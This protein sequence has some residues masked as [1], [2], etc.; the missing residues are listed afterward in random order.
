MGLTVAIYAGL[1][2]AGWVMRWQR[3]QRG[4]KLW[5]WL[6][7]LHI[8]LG[9]C[10][11][12]LILLLLS[13]G[14]VGTLGHFGSLGHSGHLPAGLSVVGLTLASA[15]AASR[16]HPQRPWARSLHLS[17]NAALF[18]ALALVSWTGWTVV[19]KYLP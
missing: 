19:Q 14:I 6:H 5:R 7:W 4:V 15:W 1:A 9:I 18:M 8:T 17:L 12:A 16:I 10:L 3:L 2:I 13:I 11:V